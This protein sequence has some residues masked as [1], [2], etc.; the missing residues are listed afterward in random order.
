VIASD[1]KPTLVF[2]MN[3]LVKE[4]DSF[5]SWKVREKSGEMNSAE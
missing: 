3:K 5:F 4:N 1:W 2:G